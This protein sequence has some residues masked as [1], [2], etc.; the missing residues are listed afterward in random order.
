MSAGGRTWR[1]VRATTDA[2]PSSARRFMARARQ[3]KLRAVVPWA[4]TAGVLLVAGA[5][6][7][8]VYGTAVLGVRAVRLDG[9]GVVPAREGER[10][11]AVTMREPLARVDLDAI[12]ARVEALPPVR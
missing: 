3:R 7:W 9:T 11:A 10:T 6:I 12:R 4:V 8:M 5:L 1:R 2:V